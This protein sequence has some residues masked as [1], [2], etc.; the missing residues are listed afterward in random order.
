MKKSLEAGNDL[1]IVNMLAKK[2]LVYENNP[3]GKNHTFC[4]AKSVSG[5]QQG[6]LGLSSNVLKNDASQLNNL[7]AKFPHIQFQY[8]GQ[9]SNGLLWSC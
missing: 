6:N 2:H 5:P 8:L 7:M 4:H 3:F 1:S 9:E